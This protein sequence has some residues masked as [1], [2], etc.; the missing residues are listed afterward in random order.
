M[1]L[2]TEDDIMEAARDLATLL[3]MQEDEAD[4]AWRAA[5]DEEISADTKWLAEMVE[6]VRG[7]ALPLVLPIG[8]PAPGPVW[9]AE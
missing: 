7:P 1:T 5:L 3:A 8:L 4:P 9:R 2:Y 6:A